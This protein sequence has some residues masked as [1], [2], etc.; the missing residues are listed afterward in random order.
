MNSVTFH[1]LDGEIR[2]GYLPAAVLGPWTLTADALTAK[3]VS[4]DAFR[5]S[6][7]PVTFRVNRQNAE[8]WIWPVTSLRIADG[9]LTASLKQE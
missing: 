8:P 9:T 4:F 6:Q 5:A 1:G 2:W 7:Q 3:V